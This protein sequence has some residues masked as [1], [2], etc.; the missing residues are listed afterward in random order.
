VGRDRRPRFFVLIVAFFR[1]TILLEHVAYHYGHSPGGG[2]MIPS[3]APEDRPRPRMAYTKSLGQHPLRHK[4]LWANT[5]D[6]VRGSLP[7][8]HPARQFLDDISS[9]D[10]PSYELPGA[11]S[12]RNYNGGADHSSSL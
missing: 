8:L 9:A 6:M 12:H 3:P 2:F 5:I 7:E 1:A 4:A 10:I 11:A